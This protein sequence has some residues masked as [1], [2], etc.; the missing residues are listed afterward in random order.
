MEKVLKAGF[1]TPPLITNFI[2]HDKDKEHQEIR[3]YPFVPKKNLKKRQ[4][5]VEAKRENYK[6]FNYIHIDTLPNFLL[7]QK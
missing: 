5:S 6:M 2:W 3:F 1:L 4:L 7:Y